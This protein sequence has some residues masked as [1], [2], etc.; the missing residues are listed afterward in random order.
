MAKRNMEANPFPKSAGFLARRIAG[1]VAKRLPEQIGEVLK[2]SPRSDGI[3]EVMGNFTGRFAVA[4]HMLEGGGESK[5]NRRLSEVARLMVE[6]EMLDK[7]TLLELRLLLPES[8]LGDKV[9]ARGLARMN[10]LRNILADEHDMTRVIPNGHPIMP[11]A[12]PDSPV[13]CDRLWGTVADEF[14]GLTRQLGADSDLSSSSGLLD[15]PN[16]AM[17]AMAERPYA[18]HIFSGQISSHPEYAGSNFM[19]LDHVGAPAEMS[20]AP[21][22][23]E[24][25]SSAE[26]QAPVAS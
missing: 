8:A 16:L 18:A 17:L 6:S 1:G 11:T 5:I 2:L 3:Q 10:R 4:G 9:A 21:F 19:V 14:D 25:E 22:P 26:V 7:K 23:P 13:D 12:K 15:P 24:A 20:L